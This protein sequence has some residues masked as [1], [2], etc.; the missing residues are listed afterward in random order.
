MA[1]LWDLRLDFHPWLVVVVHLRGSHMSPPYRETFLNSVEFLSPLKKM[2]NNC[3][4]FV[5][6]FILDKGVIL[7][8]STSC[9]E[10]RGNDFRPS[11]QSSFTQSNFTHKHSITLLA[12]FFS[13]ILYRIQSANHNSIQSLFPVLKIK[14]DKRTFSIEIMK[15]CCEIM[16][17][18]VNIIL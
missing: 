18:C 4:F 2:N 7:S 1:P 3:N 6:L 11:L 13:F 9:Y 15:Y 17:G 12:K 5:F 16:E 8:N 10:G 14:L